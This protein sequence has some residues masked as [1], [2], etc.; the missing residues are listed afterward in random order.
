MED[1]KH[2]DKQIELYL[3]QSKQTNHVKQF[4]ELA[5]QD[6]FFVCMDIRDNDDYD[7]FTNVSTGKIV[8]EVIINRNGMDMEYRTNGVI[9]ETKF[10]DVWIELT[11]DNFFNTA[12]AYCLT[13]PFSHSMCD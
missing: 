11:T 7:E 1:N 9:I 13:N 2:R 3:K 5:T 6:S 10:N 4:V 12:L 8:I